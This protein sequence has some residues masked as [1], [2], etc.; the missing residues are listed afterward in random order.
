MSS[1]KAVLGAAG[2]GFLH[3]VNSSVYP[4]LASQLQSVQQLKGAGVGQR[5]TYPE[6]AQTRSQGTSGGV[7]RVFLGLRGAGE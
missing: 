1:S 3:S 7:H 6:E 4:R 5:D 2:G